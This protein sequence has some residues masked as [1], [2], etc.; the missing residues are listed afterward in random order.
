ME[1]DLRDASTGKAVPRDGACWNYDCIDVL[2]APGMSRSPHY[3]L[4][5][6]VDP[7]S[8]YD[9]AT[10][11]IADPL[12]P[13][14]G[15]PDVSWNGKGW[16]VECKCEGGKWRTIA[17]IPYSDFGVAAPKPGD[18][19]FVNV[20]RIAKAGADGKADILMLWSPNMETRSMADP[21]AMGRLTFR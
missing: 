15:K 10:G 5:W 20:G 17:T 2:I 6:N 18:S 11:L 21:Q 13:M 8:C 1:S 19:W 9:D 14:F 16:Q 7:S 12:D 3:H 4:L